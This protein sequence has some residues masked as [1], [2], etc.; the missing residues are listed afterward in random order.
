MEQE[1]ITAIKET[2]EHHLFDTAEDVASIINE[3]YGIP[4][5]DMKFEC[6]N[7]GYINNVTVKIPGSIEKIDLNISLTADGAV[8]V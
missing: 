3:K 2:V 4:K 1:L 5:E 7:S 8:V 6:V